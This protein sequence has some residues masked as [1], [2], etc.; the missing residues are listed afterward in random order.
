MPSKNT[1]PLAPWNNPLY[2]DNPMAPHNSPVKKDDILKPWNKLVWSKSDLTKE[3][4][5]FY[6]I[7]DDAKS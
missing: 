5:R 2:K 4:K 1:A 6:G 3:E 7:R